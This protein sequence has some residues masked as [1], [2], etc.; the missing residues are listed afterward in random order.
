M[1]NRVEQLISQIVHKLKNDQTPYGTW[2]YPFD[3]GISTDAYMIILIRSLEMNDEHLVRDLTERILSK[4]EANGAWKL[5][6]DEGDGNLSATVE[7]YYSLLYAGYVSKEDN[8]M[9]AAKKFILANGGL[10]K[11]HML[12]K[13]MLA[14]T[15]QYPWP[16]H[17]PIPVEMI[18][19]PLHFP[20]NFYDFSVFGRAN[21]AP[22]MIVANNKYV[23]TTKRSPN[24]SDL[25]LSG[26]ADN[27]FNIQDIQEFLSLIEH[28]L[29]S[30]LGFPQ[31]IHSIAINRTKQYMLDHI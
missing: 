4:Q 22:I 18:L 14:L 23:R 3:T 17:F 10:E 9:L 20:I 2:T 6:Y 11:T 12:T 19:L 8:R 7:A 27:F 29:T 24:L 30:L 15:G 1:T 16:P 21:L 31:T 5:F 13:I 28:D 26:A 25:S